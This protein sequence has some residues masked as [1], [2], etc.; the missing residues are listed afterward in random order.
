MLRLLRPLYLTIPGIV[1]L[2][3][4]A[5]AMAV[6][7]VIGWQQRTG[8]GPE[9]STQLAT[10]WE[11]LEPQASLQETSPAPTQ[12][13]GQGADGAITPRTVRQPG[14]ASQPSE[15]GMEES[16]PI[17]AADRALSGLENPPG[18]AAG[19]QTE[20]GEPGVGTPVAPGEPSP[21]P[22][23][24]NGSGEEP[25][26]PPETQLP[27][28]PS[29]R[30]AEGNGTAGEVRPES[31]SYGL[32][33]RMSIPA[34]G[35]DYRV[36]ESEIRDGTYAVP[37]W[38]IGHHSDSALPGAPG[39]SVYNGHLDHLVEGWVFANLKNLKTGDMVYVYTPTHR[40]EWVVTSVGQFPRP[41]SSFISPSAEPRITLYTCT[42]TLDWA[43]QKYSHWLV[44]TGSMVGVEPL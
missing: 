31:A 26:N 7:N 28:E 42:G 13:R 21:A 6:P 33:V 9:D 43:T 11:E 36:V 23:A 38:A 27:A 10:R 17:S 34:I 37:S 3:A 2:L 20:N 39:N 4:A 40:T 15:R 1:L 25:T 30:P 24:V 44:V 32:P 41:D 5:A 29:G 22:E 12:E 16:P 19:G 14:A 8:R 35:I 18:F